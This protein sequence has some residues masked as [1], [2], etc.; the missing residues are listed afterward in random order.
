MPHL[1]SNP[2]PSVEALTAAVAV[3]LA[4]APALVRALG[5]LSP[6]QLKELVHLCREQAS[7]ERR[8]H[9][10]KASFA[11]D[12]L[13]RASAAPARAPRMRSPRGSVRGAILAALAEAGEPGMKIAELVQTVHLS[14]KSVERWVF[15]ESAKRTTGFTK[16]GSAH[17]QYL[18]LERSG[19]VPA[20]VLKS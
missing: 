11:E 3:A 7:L 2:P 6:G 16:I 1:A 4:I 5:G 18:P 20:E 17:Y 19:S 13:P 12:L 15:S 9:E 10:L 14:R 8:V